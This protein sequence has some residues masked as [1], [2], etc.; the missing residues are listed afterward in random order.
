MR[1]SFECR[2]RS[3]CEEVSVSRTAT[4]RV[5]AD[6]PQPNHHS[7]AP[8]ADVCPRGDSQNHKHKHGIVCVWFGR[9]H[10]L[11]NGHVHT[12]VTVRFHCRLQSVPAG[13]PL[14]NRCAPCPADVLFQSFPGRTRRPAP[15]RSMVT[16]TAVRAGFPSSARP[17]TPTQ[18][19]LPRSCPRG[20]KTIIATGFQMPSRNLSPRGQS[21]LR[22]WKFG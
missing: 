14:R 19:R 11:G 8:T 12:G 7:V 1:V 13:T 6:G 10:P 22:P 18:I 21:K 3:N 16:N 17:G 15:P 5:N 2:K 4:L 20:D 9:R